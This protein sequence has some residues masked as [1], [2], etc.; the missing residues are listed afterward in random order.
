MTAMSSS[1]PVRAGLIGTGHYATAVLAQAQAVPGLTIV[2]VADRTVPVALAACRRAGLADQQVAVCADRPAA[3]RA[4]EARRLVVTDDPSLLLDLPLDIVAEAT[5]DPEA[6]TRH[7][8]AAIAAGKHVAM[9]SK[10]PDVVVGPLLKRRADAAGLVYT[11]VAGDQHGLLIE[12]VAWCRGLGLELLCGGKARDEEYVLDGDSIA[13]AGR[14]RVTVP[15]ASRWA[16]EP[17]APGEAARFVAARRRVLAGWPSAAEYDLC[18]LAIAANA[19]GLLP[20]RP[21]L[22]APAVRTREIPEVLCPA[23]QGGLLS[24]GGAIEAVT[25][26]RRPESAGLGRRRVRRGRLRSDYAR[27]ILTTKGLLANARGTACLI[28]RPYHLCGVETPATLL[29]AGRGRAT[30]GLALRPRVDLVGRTR[31]P[32][33][34][35]ETLTGLTGPDWEPLLMPTGAGCPLY[36]LERARLREDLAAGTVV[37]A[38]MVEPPVGSVLW[39]LRAE[40]DAL[41]W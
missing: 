20:D 21:A 17:I 5:G 6:G 3:L 28:Y 27:E 1:P 15:A 37:T 33:R 10:E 16:F 14:G 41:A 7:A 29:A 40:Q 26:L 34:A 2:A 11:P 23:E 35:G 30:E 22:H 12:L 4:I 8:L 19:T 24:A 25:C 13:A 31:R 32:W 39:P 36:L 38:A 9:V 18:E